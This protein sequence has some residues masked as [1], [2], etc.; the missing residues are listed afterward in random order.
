MTLWTLEPRDTL[1]IRD[2]RPMIDAGGQMPGLPVPF[3][4]STA[5]FLRTRAGSDAHGRWDGTLTSD[6]AKAIPVLGPWLVE[7]DD[8]GKVIDHL[9][10]CPRD[11]VAWSAA[12]GDGHD[13]RPLAPGAFNAGEA[14]DMPAELRPLFLHNAKKEKPTRLPSFVSF[15]GFVADW[16]AKPAAKTAVVKGLAGLPK[17]WRTH[18]AINPD[19]Q[20]AEDGALFSLE[21]L[22]FVTSDGRHHRRFALAALATHNGIRAGAYPYAGE[23]RISFLHATQQQ[24]PTCPKAVVDAVAASG[25][26][27][28]LLITPAMFTAGWRPTRLC[29]GATLVA[30]AV[31]RPDVVSGWDLAQPNGGCPK[32]TRRLAPA[33]SVYWLQLDGDAAARRAWVAKHWWQPVNDDDVDDREGFGLAAIGTWEDA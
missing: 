5:G 19:T 27:R 9:V 3:P 14:S 10:P 15:D 28:V 21:H 6:Q 17:E 33:G 13:I 1:V 29:A 23:R 30:A 8:A 25:R 7:L 20:T 11:A 22:R 26:A 2:G 18:V 16:L 4:S 12:G 31:S 32:P 24:P